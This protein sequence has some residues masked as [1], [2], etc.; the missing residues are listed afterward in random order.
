MLR[1]E[2]QGVCT[3]NIKD[4]KAYP[5]NVIANFNTGNFIKLLP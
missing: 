5:I 2:A 4:T 3:K 1:A